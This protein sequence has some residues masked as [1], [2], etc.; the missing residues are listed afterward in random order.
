MDQWGSFKQQSETNIHRFRYWLTRC[1][2]SYMRKRPNK[3]VLGQSWYY[4]RKRGGK[5]KCLDKS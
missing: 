4:Y 1:S 2:A 3:S 5:V